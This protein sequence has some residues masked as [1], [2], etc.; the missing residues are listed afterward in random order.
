MLP[1]LFMLNFESE[2]EPGGLL[3][4]R[5]LSFEGCNVTVRVVAPGHSTAQLAGNDVLD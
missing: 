5:A 2:Q 4:K 1:K 3:S